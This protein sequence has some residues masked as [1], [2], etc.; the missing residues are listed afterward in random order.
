MPHDDNTIIHI[1]AEA[2]ENEAY[3]G[4]SSKMQNITDRMD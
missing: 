4:L 3:L 1:L 2:N